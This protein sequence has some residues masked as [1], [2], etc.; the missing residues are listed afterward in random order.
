LPTRAE[1]STGSPPPPSVAASGEGV[2][3]DDTSS[4]PQ[5]ASA[6]APRRRESGTRARTGDLR[7]GRAFFGSRAAS[8]AGE[9]LGFADRPR[10][11]GAVFGSCEPLG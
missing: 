9:A 10:G 11:R 1:L 4:G 3:G 6:A 2:V 5:P 8:P 7:S